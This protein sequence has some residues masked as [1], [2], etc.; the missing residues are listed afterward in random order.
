MVDCLTVNLMTNMLSSTTD[1][2]LLLLMTYY[3]PRVNPNEYYMCFLL[4][5]GKHIC[6]FRQERI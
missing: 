5:E 2:I 1:K 3:Y 6:R 4:G